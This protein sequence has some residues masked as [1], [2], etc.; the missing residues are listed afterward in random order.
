MKCRVFMERGMKMADLVKV[1]DVSF[2][3]GRDE[4]YALQNITFSVREGEILGIVGPN[5]AG[6][7]TLL[8][9]LE[10]LHQPESGRIITAPNLRTGILFQVNGYFDNLS[11]F[12]NIDMF[13][14]MYRNAYDFEELDRIVDLEDIKDKK[15]M[16]L[17]GGQRQRFFLALSVLNRPDILILDEPTTG[18]DPNARLMLWNLIRK[19]TGTVIVTSHYMDEV[20]NLCDRVCFVDKGRLFAVDS[21]KKL[22]NLSHV[23]GYVTFSCKDRDVIDEL[24]ESEEISRL[25]VD[26][27]RIGTERV[28]DLIETL[29]GKYGGNVYN[30]NSRKPGL[31]DAYCEITGGVIE[32]G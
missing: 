11:V 23:K 30:I 10:G 1:E 21:P 22:I 15:V 2:R 9:L 28:D 20:E 29:V 26:T 8:S 7:T 3:Y 13:Q 24:S 31:A 16:E 25:D 18:L 17:S 14:S 6:K 27:Y 32:E 12:E 19:V 5:G 4:E